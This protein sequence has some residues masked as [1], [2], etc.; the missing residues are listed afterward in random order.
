M[1]GFVFAHEMGHILGL[2]HRGAV[3]NPVTDGL[4]IPPDKN[5]M[6]PFVNPPVN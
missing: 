6:R 4:A 1:Y 5:I 3:T 2:G